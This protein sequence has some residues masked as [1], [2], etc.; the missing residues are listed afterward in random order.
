ME[1]SWWVFQIAIGILKPSAQCHLKFQI[2]MVVTF[3]P[4]HSIQ[5]NILSPYRLL[6]SEM[7][8][9][10]LQSSKCR[11]YLNTHQPVT[12]FEF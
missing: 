2:V 4:W 8:S 11:V 1:V 6:F 10:K 5:F 7:S 12:L 9:M 3:P